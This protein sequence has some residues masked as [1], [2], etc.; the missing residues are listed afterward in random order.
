[1]NFWCLWEKQFFC[2]LFYSKYSEYVQW[3]RDWIKVQG[4]FQG[5]MM[6]YVESTGSE[7]QKL[8]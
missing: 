6:P 5:A 8:D 2:H 3:L 1:M 7:I 4:E